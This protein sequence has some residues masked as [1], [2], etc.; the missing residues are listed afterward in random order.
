MRG[1]K[2]ISALVATVLLILITVAAVGIIWGAIMPM[3][4]NVLELNQACLKANSLNIDTQSGF[5]CYNSTGG[6]TVTVTVERGPETYD[7]TGI[8]FIVVTGGQ[9]KSFDNNT[10]V[11]DLLGKKTFSS[12]DVAYGT[13]TE[14]KIAP[15][16]KIGNTNRVCDV[17]STAI[18]S[19]CS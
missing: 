4:K 3:I 11:P 5:T 8:K 2:A 16:V 17:T 6:T 1:K 18:L 15:V 7:L 9:S 14:V 19:K 13:P 10:A 12:A